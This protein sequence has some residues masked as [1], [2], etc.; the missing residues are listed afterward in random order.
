[1]ICFIARRVPI[2][3]FISSAIS[4]GCLD[5]YPVIQRQKDVEMVR[6]FTFMSQNGQLCGVPLSCKRLRLCKHNVI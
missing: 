6:D 4:G 3:E 2:V 1:M 5:Y